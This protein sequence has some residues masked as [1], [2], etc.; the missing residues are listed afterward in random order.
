MRGNCGLLVHMK[1]NVVTQIEGDPKCPTNVGTL[2]AKGL[3]GVHN[4]YNPYRVKTPLKRTNPDKGVDA[5]PKWVEISWEEALSSVT[6]VLTKIRKDNPRKFIV[7]TGFGER[8]IFTR[9]AFYDAF[10]TEHFESD[11]PLCAQHYSNYLTHGT[12][13]DRSDGEYC[14]YHISAG[15]GIGPNVAAAAGPTRA[16]IRALERGMKMV[17]VDPYR[18]VEGSKGTEW[19]PIRP[20][21]DLALFLAMIDVIINEI[22]TVDTAFLKQRTNAPY[23]VKADGHYV[24]DAQSKKPM[25]WDEKAKAAKL[26]D[27]KGLDVTTLA[28]TGDYEVGGVKCKPA[29]QVIKDHVK[30]YTPEWAEQQ[31]TI[32]AA[33]IRRI[34]KEFVGEARIGSTI[35]LADKKLPF[36]PVEIRSKRGVISHKDGTHAHYATK[37]I[38]MLVGAV[39][40]P[41]ASCGF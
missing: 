2:C 14:N 15:I 24:R 25:V 3:S 4:L 30:Q 37:I 41:G 7:N 26:W 28:L 23:L 33:T 12:M 40:V 11:G 19:I 36:R 31:T 16:M 21:S 8:E 10:G 34:S 1:D 13:V 22:G 35:Q 39:D 18:T 5:D 6:T 32:P 17:V 9:E 38:S 27:D 29:F 20:G